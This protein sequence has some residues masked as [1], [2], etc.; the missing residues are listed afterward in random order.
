MRGPARHVIAVALA[1]ISCAQEK[2]SAPP[3]ASAA[4][5]PPASQPASASSLPAGHSTSTTAVDLEKLF[6]MPTVDGEVAITVGTTKIDRSEVEEVLRALQIEMQ[7]TGV[8]DHLS[9]YRVLRAAVDRLAEGAR[10]QLLAE[11]L[12]V[13]LDEDKVRLWLEDLKAR[14][15]RNPSFKVFLLRAGKDES[16]WRRDAERSVLWRQVQDEV[17]KRVLDDSETLA[18][19]YYEKNPGDFLEREGVETWRIFLKA[20]RGMVQRDR[21]IVKARAEK[22]HADAVKEPARFEALAR[23]YSNGGKGPQGGF[24]GWVPKGALK[25]SL[26]KAIYAA[27]P[28]TILPVH[29]A[30]IGYY[31]YKV[32]RRRAERRKPFDDVKEDILR[33]VY[34][35]RVANKVDALMQKLRD[36]Y[37][38]DVAIPELAVLEKEEQARIDAMKAKMKAGSG[39]GTR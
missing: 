28:N 27:K 30:P 38:A 8:P 10:R 13:K 11:E 18:R 37:P 29:E 36:K 14:I 34:P 23:Q 35:A 39:G 25:A 19:E 20:P 17:F 2:P 1:A 26:E 7:A 12:E 24:I 16:T 3:E 6:K 15:E 4:G 21:D 22:V 31:I 5:S 33:R 9:R 32:G